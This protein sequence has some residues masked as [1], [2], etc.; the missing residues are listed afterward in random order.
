MQQQLEKRLEA[1][2]GEHR[3]SWESLWQT[4]FDYMAPERAVFFR[5]PS[6]RSFSTIGEYVF[7]STAIDA[8]ERLTNL[9]ISGL[10][11]PWQK[12]FR[13]IP[14]V[15]VQDPREKEQLREF[16]AYAEELTHAA[17][18][19]SNF[20][21]E[22]QPLLIDR[23]VGGSAVLKFIPED[24]G[25]QFKALPLAECAFE[26][27]H[28]GRV[29]TIARKYK[30][31][32][33]NIMRAWPEALPV[34][35]IEQNENDPETSKH[36]IQEICTLDA[37]NNWQHLIRLKERK[38]VLEGEVHT[39]PRLFGTR[40]T[41]I[42]G[43]PYGR[44]PGLRALADVRALNKLKELSLQNAALAVSGIYTVVDDGVINPWT[45]SLDPGTFIPVA[46]NS[47]NERSI[48]VLPTA[49]NF[50]VS[51]W[52]MDD[53]RSSIQQVFVADQF[54]PLDKT[55]RSATEVSERTRIVAQ[56][57]GA[58]ISRLQ[59]ELLVPVLRA[60]FADLGKR[61][62]LPQDIQLDKATVD[63][64]FT[65]RLAQ[66]QMAMEEQN[67]IEFVQ[68][69]MQMG[70]VDPQAGLL[71]DT[72]AALRKWAEI[73]GIP[74]EVLRK[75]QEIQQIME[76]QMAQQQMQQMQEAAGGQAGEGQT[77]GAAGAV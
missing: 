64:E 71:V 12:W 77:G 17:L 63:V 5:P 46:S 22:M 23:I 76:T 28:A 40:W 15:S 19:E 43:S 9:I 2:F 39:H 11:P 8:V 53:L 41:K 33:R 50:D 4:T 54:G 72:H 30:L 73:R 31:C 13:L 49:S 65:S 45:V 16:L 47:P 32:F 56:E 61:D 37:D 36:E 55:P 58:T 18:A 62:M 69:V 20:Y 52:S 75:E 66:A 74:P 57:L 25:I 27:D 1:M 44:G 42:P 26:E 48:D 6:E 68:V 51:M 29:V 3:K 7:D 14:G 34:E 24:R 59:H 10:V 60:V 67:L 21:Q 70:Q 35:W 38:I